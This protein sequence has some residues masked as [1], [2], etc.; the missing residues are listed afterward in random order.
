MPKVR[1]VK[2]KREIE[3]PVGTNLRRAAMEAGISVYEGIHK[4]ANCRGLG[5]CATCRVR[6]TKGED[7]A[8]K[9]S[10]YEKMR[11]ASPVLKMLYPDSKHP[12]RLSCRMQVMGD[13]EVETRP[14]PNLHGEAFWE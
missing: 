6:I 1:F 8:S 12:M 10:F 9:M 3:V 4:L 13:M 7:Q 14:E 11:L 5:I 2:E